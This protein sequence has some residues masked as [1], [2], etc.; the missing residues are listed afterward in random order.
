MIKFALSFFIVST[1]SSVSWAEKHPCQKLKEACNGAGF[2][3]GEAKSNKG[4]VK[5]CLAVLMK[6]G[7]VPGISAS[8]EDIQA[9]KDKRAEKKA[10]AKK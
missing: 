6:G 10:H 7:S 3:P 1:L 4:L 9:C 5:D 2:M 8:S